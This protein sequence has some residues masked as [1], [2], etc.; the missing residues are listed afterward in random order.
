MLKPY[1]P[2][3][4]SATQLLEA[5]RV[6]DHQKGQIPQQPSDV[7]TSDGEKEHIFRP[8]ILEW[9]LWVGCAP[10]APLHEEL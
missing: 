8:G 1:Q 9:D 2:L 4:W 3:L 7:I 6:P 5:Q 10:R